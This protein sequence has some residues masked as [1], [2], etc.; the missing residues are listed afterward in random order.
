MRED[1]KTPLILGLTVL[2]GLL[3]FVS[4][5]FIKVATNE[6]NEL[7]DAKRAAVIVK[8]T[9]KSKSQSV[10]NLFN[11]RI[12]FPDKNDTTVVWILQGQMVDEDE[13]FLSYGIVK[14]KDKEKARTALFKGGA[15]RFVRSCNQLYGPKDAW[16]LGYCTLE[17][18]PKEQVA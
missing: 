4:I 17:P 9:G 7:N 6:K 2:V 18:F 1:I 12:K 14:A 5:Y 10:I 8:L 16:S 13:L 3:F 15:K 11:S